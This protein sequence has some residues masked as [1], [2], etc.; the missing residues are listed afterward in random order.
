[1]HGARVSCASGRATRGQLAAP[2]ITTL[3]LSVGGGGGGFSAGHCASLL[4]LICLH[5]LAHADSVCQMPPGGRRLASAGGY[6]IDIPIPNAA[7]LEKK[8]K[9]FPINKELLKKKVGL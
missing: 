1:M 2:R 8:L 7:E 4:S 9:N 3:S 6:S 5:V